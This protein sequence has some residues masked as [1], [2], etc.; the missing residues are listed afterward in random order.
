MSITTNIKDIL[1]TAGIANF[2]GNNIL[3]PAVDWQMEIGKLPQEPDQVIAIMP[4]AGRAPNPKWAVDYPSI[5]ILVR[6]KTNAYSTAE[7]KA[8]DVKDV[9]LGYYSADVNGDRI[10]AINM[11]SDV[12]GIGFDTNDR[13]MFST[14][15]ALIVEPSLGELSN[16]TAL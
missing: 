1:Y 3:D 2:P 12:A 7:A 14:N 16:R 11:I 6:G 4:G 15:F 13:P 5:Q 10:V 9:L 8:Q